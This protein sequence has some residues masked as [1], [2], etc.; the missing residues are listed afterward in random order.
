ML[1]VH[2]KTMAVGS[3]DFTAP[4]V[5]LCNKQTVPWHFQPLTS[6]TPAAPSCLLPGK[7]L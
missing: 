4:S 7:L 5:L 3:F 6:L 2:S 1:P